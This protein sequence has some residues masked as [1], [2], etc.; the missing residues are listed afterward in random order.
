MYEYLM[1][2][3]ECHSEKKME[4]EPNVNPLEGVVDIPETTTQNP[5]IVQS[6]EMIVQ[7][8]ETVRIVPETIPQSQDIP[9]SSPLSPLSESCDW[10]PEELKAIT[11]LLPEDSWDES[12]HSSGNESDHSWKVIGEGGETLST[13]EKSTNDVEPSV[14][15]HLIIRHNII[16]SDSELMSVPSSPEHKVSEPETLIPVSSLEVTSSESVV[17]SIQV[18]GSE[19]GIQQQPFTQPEP[20]AEPLIQQEPIDSPSASIAPESLVT[21]PRPTHKRGAVEVMNESPFCSPSKILTTAI[22]ALPVIETP[23]RPRKDPKNSLG[24]EQSPTKVIEEQEESKYHPFTPYQES[25]FVSLRETGH[26]L[27]SKIRRL[28][29]QQEEE[30]NRF[31]KL[32]RKQTNGLYESFQREREQGK[33]IVIQ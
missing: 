20:S 30:R 11:E 3:L 10:K 13:S 7:P 19:L 26:P 32:I 23:T 27:S 22:P 8:L 14:E 12:V 2:Q 21:P 16:F 9:I 31:Q 28:L 4:E 25:D 17:Q 6:Q 29:I 24:L 18:D 15:S 1:V 5:V 33:V